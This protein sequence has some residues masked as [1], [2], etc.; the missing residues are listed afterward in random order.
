MK[1]IHEARITHLSH[2]LNI[3]KDKV[4]SELLK[5]LPHVLF[6]FD[7]AQS[8]SHATQKGA[9][10]LMAN[11]GDEEVVKESGDSIHDPLKIIRRTT[12]NTDFYWNWAWSI[13]VSTYSAMPDI[14]PTPQADSSMRGK[15]ARHI[16]PFLYQDSF[17]IFAQDYRKIWMPN[18]E[19]PDQSIVPENALQY[20]YSWRRIK[21][22]ISCGRPLF[23]SYVESSIGQDNWNK[24][25]ED[26]SML[27]WTDR[28]ETAFPELIEMINGK[29]N[30]GVTGELDLNEELMYALLSAS[31]GLYAFPEAIL[32]K[33]D[34]V[35]RRMSWVVRYNVETRDVQISY[36]SEGMF[37]FVLALCLEKNLSGFLCGLE[38]A[39]ILSLFVN[40][41]HK[42]QFDAWQVTEIIAR[43]LFLL[44]LH[45]TDP[46]TTIVVQVNTLLRTKTI[47]IIK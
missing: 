12:R 1:C 35:R 44:A 10:M 17:D 22:I 26:A 20:I 38:S 11:N 31:V 36:P 27:A 33:A 30:G 13:A 43:L 39:K 19:Q 5:C 41:A 24:Q 32:Y 4:Q 34:M 46:Q 23:Y 42:K 37:N 29:I 16:P 9:V 28:A 8:L 25:C 3:S 45:R 2:E 14:P 47:I 21:H 6:V 15:G 40:P 7:E 18:P